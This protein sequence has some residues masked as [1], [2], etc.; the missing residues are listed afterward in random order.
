[1]SFKV[2]SEQ[3]GD[4]AILQCQGRLVRGDAIFTLREAVTAFP[5][6]RMLVLDL[7]GV[8]TMDGGGLGMLTL[9]HRWTGDHG[10]TLKLVN[11][12]AFVRELLDRTRLV[13]VFDISSVDDVV[14][15][16]CTPEDATV[17][18]HTAHA[19]A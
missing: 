12:N 5:A 10:T 18:E 8:E 6:V 7:S 17:A 4:V 2:R 15:I 11:P 1:M 16:L 13:C 14:E 9:L 19:V 3:I